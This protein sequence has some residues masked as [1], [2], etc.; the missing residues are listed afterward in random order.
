MDRNIIIKRI[1]ALLSKTTE[2]GATEAEAL[3]AAQK[4][5]ELL[6]KYDLTLS[7]IE[8]R[9]E[10][11]IQAS[12][13]VGNRKAH[14]VQYVAVAVGR[15]TDCKIWLHNSYQKE[16]RFFGLRQ[17]VEIAVYLTNLLKTALDSEWSLFRRSPAYQQSARHGRTQRAAFM[18]GMAGRI[19]DRLNQMKNER[20]QTKQTN[21]GTSLIIVKNQVVNEQFAKLNMKLR[22][23]T[24]RSHIRDYQAYSAGQAA[25]NRVSINPGVGAGSAV[26]KI[27]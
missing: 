10:T 17:D 27:A 16:I 3:A 22:E 13:V 25:G 26:R 6:D 2:N 12:V 1:A 24:T 19:T 9:D 4:A 15:Y 18:R 7:E 8:V 5:G 21:T 11:C 14:E 20:E 23:N